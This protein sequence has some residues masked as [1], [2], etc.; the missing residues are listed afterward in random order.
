[1]LKL[2][3]VDNV[4]WIL[5]PIIMTGWILWGAFLFFTQ[6]FLHYTCRIR[7]EGTEHFAELP[8]VI[9]CGWHI[10]AVPL[11]VSQRKFPRPEVHLAWDAWYEKPVHWYVRSRGSR[12][13]ICMLREGDGRK[14]V[15]RLVEYLRQGYSTT[16]SPDAR[17]AEPKEFRRGVLHIAR[18]SGLPIIPLT[19]EVSHTLVWF[20]TWDS[21][22]MPLPFSRVTVRYGEPV[23]VND[24]NFDEAE[25]ILRR[26]LG[27]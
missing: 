24:D 1:V 13:L 26:R 8:A 6:A 16:V 15:A 3:R 10:N 11:F 22:R 25:T 7:L 18:D 5:M 12:A 21:K 19:T 2:D 9:F 17:P 27:P 14:A 20:W 4:P 23:Y